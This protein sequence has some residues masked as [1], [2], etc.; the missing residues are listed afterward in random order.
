MGM[1]YRGTIIGESLE[2]KSIFDKVKVIGTRVEKVTKRHKTQWLRQWTIYT[3]EIPEARADALAG[4]ISR[5]I[6]REHGHAWYVNFKN[7]RTHYIIFLEKVFKV[8]RIGVDGY[9]KVREYGI[10]LGIPE[11]QL[12]FS[13]EVEV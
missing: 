7:D 13:P 3:I 6:V 8:D 4:V 12:D 1:D 5:S 9:Q 10:S 11:Y 2:D